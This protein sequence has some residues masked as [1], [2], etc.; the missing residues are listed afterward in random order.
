M[1]ITYI[2]IAVVI[3]LLLSGCGLSA[4]PSFKMD[5]ALWICTDTVETRVLARNNSPVQIGS[6]LSEFIM[7]D[8]L[9]L[10]DDMYIR[11]IL[12]GDEGKYNIV[13]L[14]D[15]K[16]S[17][18]DRDSVEG[19][20]SRYVELRWAG[21]SASVALRNASVL[22]RNVASALPPKVASSVLADRPYFPISEIIQARVSP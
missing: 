14:F 1:K 10:G 5:S 13:I 11:P 18:G 3:V 20:I 2:K 7:T 6:E 8:V 17:K 9:K 15:P 4:E 19:F 22:P 12:A 16:P 21:F